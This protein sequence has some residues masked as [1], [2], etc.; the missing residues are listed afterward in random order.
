MF[1]ESGASHVIVTSFVFRSGKIDFDRLKM[2]KD[3]AGKHR[4]VTKNLRQIRVVFRY[5]I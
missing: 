4:L 1:L 2:L 5:L 3:V